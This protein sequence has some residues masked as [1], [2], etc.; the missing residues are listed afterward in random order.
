LAYCLM[1]NHIHLIAV[2]LEGAQWAEVMH[3]VHGRYAQYFNARGTRCGH[4]WQNRFGSCALG[5]A[6][7]WTARRYV[8][9]NPV[10]TGMVER[11][12]NFK[13]SSTRAHLA[14]QDPRRL[15]DMDFWRREGGVSN[16]LHLLIEPED[17]SCCRALRRTTYSGQPFG[18]E[19]FAEKLRVLR[20]KRAQSAEV[21]SSPEGG[22]E[23]TPTAGGVS[24]W[25]GGR[26]RL[27]EQESAWHGY[28]SND[29]NR[30]WDIPGRPGL[31]R[32]PPPPSSTPS[33]PRP[34]GS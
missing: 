22:S 26:S 8:E 24:C 16:W 6:H 9:L 2:P 28:G 7:L 33:T 25:L 23:I 27:I 31:P 34:A 13:W 32:F 5:P 15:L 3:R 19:R 18:D 4:L 20:G 10:R 12:E 30:R 29:C 1:S 21:Y 17:E 11:I 14:G